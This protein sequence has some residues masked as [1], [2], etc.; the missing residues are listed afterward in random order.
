MAPSPPTRPLLGGLRAPRRRGFA[1]ERQQSLNCSSS[2]LSYTA[3]RRPVLLNRGPLTGR[4]PFAA[5]DIPVTDRAP[6]AGGPLRFM[7]FLRAYMTQTEE[8][9]GA[10]LSELEK[11]LT[12]GKGP[13]LNPKAWT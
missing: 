5:W 2:L 13:T 7:G 11:A 3:D 4:G 8:A 6:K 10:S 9:D 1:L 12:S